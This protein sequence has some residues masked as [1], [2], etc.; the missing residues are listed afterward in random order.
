[1]NDRLIYSWDDDKGRHT[2]CSDC[3]KTFGQIAGCAIDA[4]SK[5]FVCEFCA[6]GASLDKE[7]E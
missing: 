5:D 2:V 7:E 1:M 3:L 4:N 6:R